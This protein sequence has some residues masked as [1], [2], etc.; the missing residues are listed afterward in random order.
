MNSSFFQ[1]KDSLIEEMKLA[2]A[3]KH[4]T[5]YLTED[6]DDDIMFKA[7][8]FIDKIVRDD[9]QEGVDKSTPIKLI[10]NSYGGSIYDGLGL[11]AKIEHMQENGYEFHGEVPSYAMSMGSALLQVCK[12]RVARRYATILYHTPLSGMNGTLSDMQTSMDE[13]HRL[14]ELMKSISLKHTKMTKEFLDSMYER[15]KDFYMTP[16]EAL[17]YGI[18]DEIL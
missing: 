1:T 8:Y 16:E 7:D 10:I 12:H 15:N 6:V 13:M 11:I 17:K 2:S 5:I 4:R 3:I 18:I 9:I 14:W